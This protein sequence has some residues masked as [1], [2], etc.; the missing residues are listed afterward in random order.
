MTI[1]V[2]S[3]CRRVLAVCSLVLPL[4]F[5]TSIARA[6]HRDPAPL[7]DEVIT[8]IVGQQQQ[9][10]DPLAQS[11]RQ[12][13]GEATDLLSK[14]N[15][16]SSVGDAARTTKRMLLHAKSNELNVVQGEL[17]TRFAATRKRLVSLGLTKQVADLDILL[18]KVEE[19]FDRVGR[20]FEE[21]RIAPDRPGRRKAVAKALQ[22]LHELHGKILEQEQA[23]GNVPLPTWKLENRP[24]Q[25]P[26]YSHA[27]PP[28]FLLSQQSTKNNIYAF[29][30]NTLLAPVPDQLPGEAL[31]CGYSAADLGESQEIKLTAEIRGLAQQLG[32]SPTRILE[33]VSNE[34]KYEPYYGSLKGATGTLVAKAGNATD[35]TSLLI[36]LLRASNIPARY[37]KGTVYSA[38]EE[39]LLRWL[40]VK[41]QTAAAYVLNAGGIP[42]SLDSNNG[43]VQFTHVW[44]EACV[45][46]AHYRGVKFDNA[47]FRWIPL[48]PSFKDKTY[49][50]GIA[51]NVDF[52][53]TTYMATRSNTLPFEAYEQQVETSIKSLAPNYNNNTLE[54]VPYKG[55]LLQRKVDILPASPP[56][57]IY[58]YPAWG[59]GITTADTAEVPDSHRIKFAIKVM[60]SAGTSLASTILSLPETALARTTISYKGAT[61]GDQTAL[62]AW[63]ADGN[64][65]S[66]VPGTN[67]IPCSSN[68]NVVPVIKS[69]GVDKAVGTTAVDLCTTNNQ[70]T[71]DVKLAEIAERTGGSCPATYAPNTPCYLNH[72]SYSNIGAAN[73]HA[74]LAYA[75][76]ASD[77][78]LTERSKRLLDS[79]R[80]TTN[81]ISNLEETEG[82]F[83]NIVGLKYLRYISDAN[84]RIGELNGSTGESGNH[85]GLTC[86][87]S[88]VQYLFDL[89]FAVNRV[90][91]LVDVPGG[92]SRDVDISSGKSAWKTFQ[93]SG[94]TSSAYESYI[95]QENSRLD[96]VST[97]RGIQFARESGIE[98]LTLTSS[99][100]SVSGDETTCANAS[101]Q[102]YKFTH[103]S[104]TALN[105][106]PSQV[107]TIYSSY[108]SQGRTL[109]IPRSLIQYQTWKGAVFVAEKNDTVSGEMHGTYAI[110]Q[111]AGG[112]TVSTPIPYTYTSILDTGYLLPI[113]GTT[114]TYAPISVGNGAISNG[115]TT[116]NTTSGDPVNMVTGNVYHTERDLSIKGRGGLPL[117]FERS[118][119]SRNPVD[120]N[121]DPARC[122]M[123]FGWTHSFN[124]YLTFKD[125]NFNGTTEAADTDGVTSAVSWTDGTGSEK[126][127]Q[128]TGNGSGVPI[129]STFTPP[130]GFFFQV[131]RAA[132]GT[133]TLREKNGLTY[134]FENVAGTVNQKARLTS[135]R[136]RN[137]NTL[138]LAYP[139]G[140]VTIT[141][142]L[143]RV[144]N[145]TYTGSRISEVSDWTGRKHQYSYD[146]NGNLISYKNPLAVAGTQNPVTYDY[147]GASDGINLNHAMKKYTLPRGNGMT[148]EY[149][150]N[151]RAFRHYNTLNET[152]TF[153]YNDFRRETVQVNERGFTRHFFFDEYGNPEKIKEE[154]GAQRIYGYDP[155]N[156]Y[157]RTSKKDPEGYLT[158]YQYDTSGN[159]TQITNPSN[160]TVQYSYFNTFNQPGKLKDAR[161]NYTLYKYDANGNLL[162]EI[163]L[164]NGLGAAANPATYVPVAGDIVA[165]T[166][167]SYDSYGNPLTSRKVRDFDAQIASVSNLT[168]PTLEYIYNDTVNNVQGLN[169]VRITRRG[170]KD[171]NGAIS[172][173]EY[174]TASLSY[175][176]LGRLKDGIDGDW[177]ATAYDYDAVDR[178][179]R[180]TDATGN[181]RDYRFDPNGNPLE[182]KLI[183]PINT[184]PTLLDSSSSSFDLSD[185]KQTSIDSGGNSTA[186]QYDESGNV[187]KVTNPDN[188]NLSF[189]YD[190]NNRVIKA[191]DQEN[192]AVTRK[193]DLSGKPR[194]ITD[195]NGN[196]ITYEYYDSSRD[197]RLKTVTQP[198][199]QTYSSGH[200]L[201]Y[202]YDFNG[203]VT[204]VTDIPADGS[205]SR[206]TLTTF[207]ELNRPTRIV[208]PQYT[209]VVYGVI[210]PVTK[211][212]YDTLGN[213]ARVDAGRT[214]SNE[215]DAVTTQL[216]YKYDDFGRKIMETDP[217]GKSWTFEYNTNNNITKATDAKGQVTTYTW[218]YGR[219]LLTR[220]NPAGNTTYTRNALGQVTSAASP[221][222][223]YTYIYDVAHRLE[224]VTDSRGG[225]ALNYDYSPGGLLNSVTDSDDNQTDYLYD[226]VGRLSGIWAANYDTVTFRYDSGGRLTEKWFPNGVT[227][228]YDYNV[229]NSLKQ[230]VNRSNANS[231]ISQH[232]YTYDGFGNR[233]IHTEQIGSTTTPYKYLYDELNRLTEVQNNSTAALIE[234]YTYDPIGNRT[235]K[236][237]GV[238]PVYYTYDTANQL[239]EIHQ[240]G[241]TAN[242]VYDNNGNMT[243]GPTGSSLA[244][245]SLNRLV[246]AGNQ[247]YTYD[248][249]G[250][251]IAKTV[252]GTTTS[253]LYNGQDIVAEYSNWTSPTAQYTHGPNM[254]DPIIRATATAAQYFHQDGL[255]S[256]VGLSSEAGVTTGT[257]G[258]D[259]WGNKRPGGTG[260]IPQYGYT[261]REPDETGL[262]YYRAR[263]YDPTIGRFTQR[264]P[265]GLQ[266]GINQYAYVNGNPMNLVDPSGLLPQILL[267]ADNSY[268]NTMSDAGWNLGTRVSGG[269]KVIGGAAEATV[270]GALGV[271]TSWTGVGA[272][273]GGLVVL[274][275]ADQAA[276]GLQQLITG[277]PTPTVTS[278]TL[279]VFGANSGTAETIDAVISVLGT[280]GAGA[281][282]QSA[283]KLEVLGLG[284]TANLAQGTTLPRNIRE[285]LAV[286]EAISNPSAG[287]PLPF[288]M[289]DSR[290]AAS[291]GWVKMQ[292]IIKPGGEPINVHYLRNTISGMMDDFKIVL[293][294]R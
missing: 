278:Q 254:D 174:D 242:L 14:L 198:K 279:Q 42:T 97:V 164:K 249:Q 171:G 219:Q 143:G 286:Q 103:N 28:A 186:Y 191:Y 200:A 65:D 66:P 102:C 267:A 19:R 129:G 270:G 136:D 57:E 188:Y 157:N 180:G 187:N 142:G 196:T 169:L 283:T 263:Y 277:Q 118:Y 135:I 146:G 30:G 83:L 181:Q 262:I 125:G 197:G 106:N 150:A 77:R 105:Y 139:S 122:P 168:G 226:N 70:L 113:T 88:K 154:N 33:Y 269:L 255:G 192:N 85:L 159:V 53:Y 80:T 126:F 231:I 190:E 285:Q 140:K 24:F 111:Y 275:G 163:Q 104:N 259:A 167:N 229:D 32:Y 228:R 215:S 137:N 280:V 45:P 84:K 230:V 201:Q 131:A 34:I 218:G 69:E 273:A 246:T 56:Y 17:R 239:K 79:V 93:L 213:L 214:D 29:N 15:D 16:E 7:P 238:N 49:Q 282:I 256:V 161:G 109:T 4:T 73:Y 193:L 96:A 211:Y 179:T 268:F 138:T 55:V 245:D 241:T 114:T 247:S 44:A 10:D 5:I 74:L 199:I 67:T 60:N 59:G 115:L 9:P 220:T 253:Y 100:W 287:I 86:A 235:S 61:T 12:H 236:T 31:S 208:G 148:F 209:D 144:L 117:V 234:K 158:G 119:N 121:Q 75:F 107:S 133:Y 27:V 252:G 50:A 149:Y 91:Y 90:G 251:R 233:Q 210:R 147:Y 89:P 63:K 98:V 68:I 225:K 258:F 134:T 40:G 47:G 82:E 165:W 95:W 43:I 195:P 271:A 261:G 22:V 206:T 6:E 237:D 52:D 99:N 123:G 221:S 54:D 130:K 156:P 128:V 3:M 170:D 37:V 177:Q 274:H 76:Q 248:D 176:S 223:T 266:G 240:G 257:Q 18:V 8:R 41:T 166:V 175:D 13:L 124:H 162:Q 58:N 265:A 87:R 204:S 23:L 48:D 289:T 64:L 202:D 243:V 184:L 227:A 101:S 182:Q 224:S 92:V 112:Y 51:T 264:D 78:Q 291:E 39:R 25:K 250:R 38:N 244:Y 260:S 20:S 35:Q 71:L 217:L 216:T 293:P 207:D 81:P 21:V 222:V 36:A 94:Y 205:A 110:N 46:Y 290:W 151:G 194:S 26:D 132:N 276:A 141:D 11:L 120:C 272:V 284:S 152:N 2:M 178:V 232:D 62:D 72:V 281:A 212:I 108:I 172:A 292:Q 116:Y 185:R 294:R 145:L 203:N 189:D 127:I 288:K 183:L 173:N 160:A 153:T 1:P 155:A